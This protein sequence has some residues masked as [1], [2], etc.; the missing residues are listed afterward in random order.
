M[1][2]V[3]RVASLPVEELSIGADSLSY[4]GEATQVI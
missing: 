1:T 4:D 3:V 2:Q